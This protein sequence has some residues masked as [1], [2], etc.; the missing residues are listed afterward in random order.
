MQYGRNEMLIGDL[1]LFCTSKKGQVH[2]YSSTK[3]IANGRQRAHANGVE[4]IYNKKIETDYRDRRRN[5]VSWASDLGCL[6]IANI[7]L[8]EIRCNLGDRYVSV[9][10]VNSNGRS[11]NDSRAEGHHYPSPGFGQTR[12]LRKFDEVFEGEGTREVLVYFSDPPSSDLPHSNFP[13][14]W[15]IWVSCGVWMQGATCSM[16]KW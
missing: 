8:I 9:Y 1:Y 3:N 13:W 14:T 10:P 11:S 7:T 5:E 6:V 12:A 16:N 2:K 4:L 15:K